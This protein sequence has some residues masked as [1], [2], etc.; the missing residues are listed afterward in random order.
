MRVENKQSMI[1]ANCVIKVLFVGLFLL[2]IKLFGGAFGTASL[3]Y[4]VV[5]NLFSLF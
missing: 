5:L 4:W 1:F 3:I 2:E